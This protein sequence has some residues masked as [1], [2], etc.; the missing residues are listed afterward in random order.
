VGEG[1]EEAIV[2]ARVERLQPRLLRRI[3]RQENDREVTRRGVFAKLLHQDA[4]AG[5]R[6]EHVRD[7]EVGHEAVCREQRLLRAAQR[8]NVV[9]LRTQQVREQRPSLGIRLGEQNARRN[10][11][12]LVDDRLGDCRARVRRR[13]LP[14]VRIARIGDDGHILHGL[15]G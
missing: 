15:P 8:Q 10:L 11:R 12:R 2:R 6:Q 3:G 13:R 5:A 9:S 7:D 1:R 4:A 14:K